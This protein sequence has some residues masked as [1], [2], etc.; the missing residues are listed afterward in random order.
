MHVFIVNE[1]IQHVAVSCAVVLPD[2]AE[3]CLRGIATGERED[4]ANEQIHPPPELHPMY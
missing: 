1:M 3:L 2:N 4:G